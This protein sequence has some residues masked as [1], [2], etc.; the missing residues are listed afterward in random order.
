MAK[1]LQD[2]PEVRVNFTIVPSLRDQLED[3]AQ[4]ASDI[5]ADLTLRAVE[6]TLTPDERDA[7]NKI[8]TETGCHTCGI[9]NPGTKSG[10]FVPDHQ[11]PT[12][13]RQPG[14]SQDL[15]PHCIGCSRTQGGEVRRF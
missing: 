8:G 9:K 2:Y 6:G 14:E 11:P 3:Y 4:G 10:N 12:A 5:D 13:I 7:I 1:L 15:F